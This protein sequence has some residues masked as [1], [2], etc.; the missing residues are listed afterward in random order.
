MIETIKEYFVPVLVGCIC[1]LFIIAAIAGA[2]QRKEWLDSH[3]E[4]IGK[5]SSS[6]GVVNTISTGGN[7]GVGTVVIAGKTGYKCDDGLIYWE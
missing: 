2:T 1:V 6:L 7:I 4:V 3:C 5:E